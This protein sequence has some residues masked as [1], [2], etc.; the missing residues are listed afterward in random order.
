MNEA[1]MNVPIYKKNAS[2]GWVFKFSFRLAWSTRSTFITHPWVFWCSVHECGLESRGQESLSTSQ[3]IS[4]T[5][6]KTRVR[7]RRL[8]PA[9]VTISWLSTQARLLATD[10]PYQLTSA[11]R[12]DVLVLTAVV[13]DGMFIS[14]TSLPP[15]GERAPPFLTVS[16]C[17]LSTVA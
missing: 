8:V 9:R 16:L 7:V 17:S 1:S 4:S 14:V 5:D 3:K 12:G 10:P 2:G 11:C 13:C 6:P 15:G